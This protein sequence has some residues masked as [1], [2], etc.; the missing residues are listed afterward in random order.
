MTS[1]RRVAV[2]LATAVPFIASLLFSAA[3]P[4]HASSTVTNVTIA[5]GLTLT[6][7]S[8]PSGPYEIRVLTVD[9][10]TALTV[11]VAMPNATFPGVAT[12]SEMGK[13]HHALA[14]I[15]GD[16]TTTPGRPVHPFV[17]DG[18]VEQ[19]GFQFGTSFAIRQ[20]ETASYVDTPALTVRVRDGAGGFQLSAYDNGRPGNGQI[21]GFS[22]SGGTIE[23]PPKDSC[24]VRLLPKGKLTWTA[25]EAGVSKD[26]LVDAVKCKNARMAR[27]GGVVLST[28][29]SSLQTVSMVTSMHVGDRVSLSWQMGNMAG[30]M[31]SVGSSP[32]IVKDGVNVGPCCGQRPFFDRNPR[33][34]IGVTADGKQLFV[35]VD[36]RDP[37]WS[38]GMKLDEFGQLMLSLGAV[39][40]INLD[41]GGSTAMW[42][43]GMG[44]VNR[45]S[46]TEGERPVSNAVL[47]LPGP[48]TGEKIPLPPIAMPSPSWAS[49]WA[50]MSADPGSIGGLAD[51]SVAG[52]LPG[53][54]R[55][56]ATFLQIARQFRSSLVHRM[57]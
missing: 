49:V 3:G 15:N 44:V 25:G 20:D 36:G 46:D 2:A 18:S 8:D 22:R 11:D 50:R 39:N 55:V 19:T 52:E 21:S 1:P 10:S 38:V 28:P 35:V 41:G 56:P 6:S 34:G 9:P 31:D 26:Y 17:M 27:K 33:T 54:G 5:K 13:A 51:A 14:A 53:D 16:F 4:A 12:P 37:T 30:I 45:P 29:R 24:S 23:Q 40:A 32:V 42:V 7:I 57:F 48:D 43:D 47:V